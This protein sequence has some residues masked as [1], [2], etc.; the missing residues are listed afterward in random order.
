MLHDL[1]CLTIPKK[2]VEISQNSVTVEDYKGARQ[3]M[4]TM[5]ELSVGDFVISQQN[6]ILEKMSKEYAEETLNLV[7]NIKN[8]KEK[9]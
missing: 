2:V 6:I 3:E 8:G 1:V 4:I 9:L 5:I 7:L